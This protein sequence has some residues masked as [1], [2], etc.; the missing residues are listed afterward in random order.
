MSQVL[1]AVA[2]II[3]ASGFLLFG[4]RLYMMLFNFPV[5][6]K[7]RQQKL[8]EVKSVAAICF[9]SF[10]IRCITAAVSAFNA[11]ATL[12]V[13]DQPT[14]FDLIYYMLVEILPCAIVLFVHRKL[15]PKN[16]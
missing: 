12:K 15:P 2:S 14:T 13:L 10:L 1:V 5:E 11:D 16:V 3:A 4:G 8:Y 9:A 6:S 7:G